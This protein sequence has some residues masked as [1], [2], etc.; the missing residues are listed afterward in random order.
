MDPPGLALE[1]YDV[2]GGWRTSYRT[3]GNGEVVKLEIEGRRVQYKSGLPV[4][5]SGALPDGRA[6]EGLAELKRHLLADRA[7]IARCVTGKLLTYATGAGPD[8]AD[9]VEMDELVSSAGKSNH[10]LRT[11]V[12]LV[13]QSRAFQHK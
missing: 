2:I 13:V 5:A 12:H 11:L 4:D 8:F 1:N 9:R 7:Q 10:G 3:A 6:F